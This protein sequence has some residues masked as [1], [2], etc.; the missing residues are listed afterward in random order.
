MAPKR[1][2]VR[3]PKTPPRVDSRR[4]GPR[5]TRLMR[6]NET[7]LSANRDLAHCSKNY[8]ITS[9]AWS[10]GCLPQAEDQVCM[11]NDSTATSALC[12]AFTRPA[13]SLSRNGILWNIDSGSASLRLDVEG[14][15]HVAP[16]LGFVG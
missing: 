2:A 16:L 7:S 1:L 4:S 5:A 6:H 14:P 8:S 15:D 11:K 3:D 9:S 10:I 12:E 13:A